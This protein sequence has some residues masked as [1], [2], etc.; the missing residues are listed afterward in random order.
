MKKGLT[1]I[2]MTGA[3]KTTLGPLLS[4]RLGWRVQDVDHIIIEK[5]HKLIGQVVREKGRDYLLAMEAQCVT[6]LD[7]LESIL[8][9]PGSIV[10]SASCHQ[11]LKDQTTSIWLDVPLATLL[12]RFGR[13][14][15]KAGAVVGAAS[16]FEALFDE[17]KPLYS[18]LAD[19][20]IE[21]GDKEPSAIVGEII[22]RINSE[23]A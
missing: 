15:K 16:G 21:C 18:A 2:G 20:T 7:L 17:R 13:D 4:Q 10:Y 14:P 5:E 3:G 22:E 19:I 8:V 6:E 1:L 9:T 23:L 12:E 11:H